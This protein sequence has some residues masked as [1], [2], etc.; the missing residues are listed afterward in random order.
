MGAK[1]KPSS[2][3]VM[4]DGDPADPNAA[5]FKAGAHKVLD[6]KVNIA[7]EQTGLWKDTVANQKVT[8]A[9]TQLGQGTS[10]ASTP[11]TTAWPAASPP[12]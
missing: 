8:A 10:R 9:I 4:I 5:Q 2:K 1:A 6:G 7:Y 3:I 11:P 12:P